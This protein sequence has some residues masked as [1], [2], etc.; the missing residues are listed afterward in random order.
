MWLIFQ[1]KITVLQQINPNMDILKVLIGK[2]KNLSAEQVIIL[3][4]DLVY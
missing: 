2:Q 4:F 3:Q 1:E